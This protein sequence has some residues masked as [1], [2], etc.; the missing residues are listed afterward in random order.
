MLASGVREVKLLDI[1]IADVT[2]AY[3]GAVGIIWEMLMGEQIHVGGGEETDLLARRAGVHA[4]TRVLD[5]L[6]GLGGPARHLA[7]TYGATVTGLDATGRMVS[8]AVLRT[9]NAGLGDRVAFRLGN[10]LDIPFTSETFDVV[11]GQDSWCYVTDKDRLIRECRRVAVP[12]GTIAFTDWIQAGPMRDDE[13]RSLNAFML[14]PYMETL[15]GYERLLRRHGFA[16]T[17]CEDLSEDFASH[18]HRYRNALTGDLKDRIVER[19]GTDAFREMEHG[20]GLWVD[21]ADEGKVGRGRF[22]GRKA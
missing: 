5:V 2:A 16:V 20:I 15:A 14:F 22:V 11:W 9:K 10:A 12:G 6:S 19:F 3:E 7:R 4:G 17:E 13:R 21:A 18:M 8:E 1:T